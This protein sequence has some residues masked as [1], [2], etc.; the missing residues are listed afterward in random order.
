MGS[1]NATTIER[2]RE[3]ERRRHRHRQRELVIASMS[4]NN[5]LTIDKKAP[6][7]YP[8]YVDYKLK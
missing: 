2:I 6:Q 1:I 4:S 3:R 5:I 8:P 7:V